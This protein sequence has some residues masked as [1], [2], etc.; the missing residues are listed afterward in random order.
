M[1]DC[2]HVENVNFK[3]AGLIISL[4]CCQSKTSLISYMGLL[5]CYVTLGVC[6]YHQ[7]TFTAMYN[8]PCDMYNAHTICFGYSVTFEPVSKLS[9]SGFSK[10]N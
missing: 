10:L 5:R 8:R 2:F 3:T 7:I 9:S 4:P 6:V 1:K